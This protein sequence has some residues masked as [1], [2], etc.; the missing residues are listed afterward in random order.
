MAKYWILVAESS[1]ARIF[2]S[3]RLNNPA[4]KEVEDFVHPESRL[5]E[6]DLT[7]SKPGSDKNS[8]GQARHTLNDETSVKKQ[9]NL[10]FAR[11]LTERLESG[12]TRGEYK[13]L[14]LVAPP[15]FLGLLRD[16][17]S[18]ESSKL[19]VR[20]INKNLVHETTRQL[21]QHLASF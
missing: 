14:I 3:T 6:G 21:E 12:R 10:Y 20:E 2:S 15:G 4:L 17:L 13:N 18:T 8:Q 1:R 11:E 9:E 7:T 5:H 16:N 19:V